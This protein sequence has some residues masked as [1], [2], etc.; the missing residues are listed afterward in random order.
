MCLVLTALGCHPSYELIVAANRDEFLSRPTAPAG[1]WEDAPHVLAG[2]DL[3][4]GGTWMGITRRGWLA[5]LT[6]VRDPAAYLADAPSRGSLVSDFFKQEPQPEEYL[7]FLLEAGPAY[8]G[9]NLI[10]GTP[11]RL[12]YY[13]NRTNQG[14]ELEPGLHGLSND[15]LNAPWP[16][17][18]RGKHKLAEALHSDKVESMEILSILKDAWQPPDE[19]LPDTG[20]GLELE[21]FL[22]PMCISGEAYATRSSTVLLV[23]REGEVAFLEQTH[24]G[25]QAKRDAPKPEASLV[26]RTFQLQD[27]ER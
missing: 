17:V 4:E 26:S 12:L 24:Q 22:A 20:V 9:F 13:T 27:D 16:K 8:N 11:W 23:S 3:Q 25:Q 2:R 21:R 7:R 18:E 10:F 19:D 15:S 6:N 1:F 14:K 5:V